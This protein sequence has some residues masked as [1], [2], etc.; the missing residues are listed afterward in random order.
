MLRVSVIVLVC[1]VA[2]GTL[3]SLLPSGSGAA[4]RSGVTLQG[5]Q[6]SLYPEQD[7]GAVWRFQARQVTIDPLR[8]ENRLDDLGRGERWL[9]RP[10][11][12][13]TLDLTLRTRRLVIDQDDNLQAQ[14]ATMY[15]PRDC[16]T[17][18]LRSTADR[19][20][21]INQRSGYSAPYVSIDNPSIQAEYD[22]F[23]SPFDLSNVQGS[24][25]AGATFQASPDTVCEAGRTVP[26]HS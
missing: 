13:E 19:P 25:R 24:Q 12:P 2:F 21:L 15:I 11:E 18:T 6:F 14:E 9:H 17:L 23:T 26:R 5:V 20:V 10:G 4:A 7:P 16:T 22:D 1:V 3:F 8:D